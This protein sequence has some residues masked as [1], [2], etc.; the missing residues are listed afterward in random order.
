ML[1]PEPHSKPTLAG[2]VLAA[3]C[4]LLRCPPLLALDPSLDIGQYAH[5]AIGS[6]VVETGAVYSIAQTPDG[7]L[8]L[9]S[10][11]GVFRFDGVR[12]KPLPLPGGHR[13]AN[14][15]V[16]VLRVARDG[17]LWIGALDGLWSW[18]EG[19]LTEYP[20]FHGRR[21][22][23]LLEDREGTLWVATALGGPSGRLCAIRKHDASDCHGD[24]GSLGGAVDSLYEDDE[25]TLWVGA[26]TGLWRWKPGEPT[27]VL[28]TPIA[29]R[30]VIARSEDGASSLVA[31]DTF[32]E[33]SRERVTDYAV[34]G[35]P[36][37]FYA[38]S[39]LRDRDRGLWIGTDAH[40]LVHSYGGRSSAFTRADGLS[41]DEIKVLFE[42]REGTVWV[43]TGQGLD[44]FRPLQVTSFSVQQGLSSANVSSVLAARDG[45]LWIG[46]ADGLNR[47]KDGH[48]TI[49]RPG[50]HRGMPVGSILALYEDE[51]GRIWLSGYHGLASFEDG[52]FTAAPAMLT[53][54]AGSNF[55]IA[56]DQ[57]GSLWLSLWFTSSHDGLVHLVDGRISEEVPAAKLGG[58]PVTGLL[59]DP[60]GAVWAGL[61]SG[62]LRYVRDGEIRNI[63]LSPDPARN[64]KVMNLMR[65]RAGTLWAA[66]G[67]GLSRI[68]EGHVTTLT[69]ANGLP[70][71]SVHW[72]IEDD[73][74]SYWLY[75]RCG[76]LRAARSELEA[77][78]SDPKRIVQFATYDSADGVRLIPLLEGFGPPVTRSSDGKIWFLNSTR[79]SVIDPSRMAINTVPPPVHV[80]LITADRRTYPAKPGL[81]LP[82]LV[83]DLS[84]D[85]AALSLVVPEKVDFRY[86]LE[87]QDPDW[88][89]VLNKRQA[90][91]S[92]LAPGHYRFRVIAA[93]NS[94]VWNEKGAALDFSIAP[95]YWQTSWFRALCVA[96]LLAALWMLYW[97]RVRQLAHRFDLRLEAR[98]Q[99]RTRI[100]RE[101]HD[102]LLQSF[103]GALLH[104]R[105]A[106][107]L[108]SQRPDEARQVL[109][110][111]IDQARAALT[112]GR[113][114]V[115][116]LRTSIVET[117]ELRQAIEAL[118]EDLAGAAAAAA[119][120]PVEVHLSTEGTPQALRPLVRDDIYRI[121]SEALRNAF[122]HAAASRIE[123]HLGYDEQRFELRVR[124][125]G[126][127]I[128]PKFL[129]DAG[130]PGHFGLAGMRERAQQIGGKLTVSSTPETGTEIVLSLP[131][132]RAYDSAAGGR[133][134][135][136]GK[137]FRSS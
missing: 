82:P 123:V 73:A 103:N 28:S 27:R 24:D 110:N 37:P 33:V 69:T 133:A 34:P 32:R 63:P 112:E 131:S 53:G 62:G 61:V 89:E 137:F 83:R 75:T 9:G 117:N 91:Y 119:E 95:A 39:L 78:A 81:Q 49:Y 99:E 70:C 64:P 74:S 43:G 130:P 8:W 84:I 113:H 14:T 111:A 97:L 124:D 48:A 13:L 68:T 90:Q 2:I 3:S 92:N 44:R 6:D 58:G 55:V 100:A 47:W 29:G 25:G 36:S 86:K 31:T 46:T 76:L 50:D 17:T 93:N 107:R 41:S 135:R 85:Y 56:G 18:K 88:R 102:T 79:L 120:H 87:G 94:G 15:Q 122:R 121:A 66:T 12:A 129:S 40:G 4:A 22:N 21:V 114:A 136:F 109:E 52:K 30:Q 59:V 118:S 116:G 132:A 67:E 77:W 11:L 115:Q 38:T 60:D 108:L 98:V 10:Q 20:A 26:L 104:F 45:S 127:G 54:A 19:R 57:H 96:A 101:L 125:D 72:V 42:D 80:E 65:D 71:D 23:A 134:S 106:Y 16:G 5:T 35:L 7:Y 1:E 51:R 126:K 128:D 105:A